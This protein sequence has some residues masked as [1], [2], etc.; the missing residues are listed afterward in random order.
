MKS[1]SSR[2]GSS[3]QSQKNKMDE[4]IAVVGVV[5]QDQLLTAQDVI[6]CA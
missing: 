1:R 6:G 4:P 3:Q 2:H 5:S